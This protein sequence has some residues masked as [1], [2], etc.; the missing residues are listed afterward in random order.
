MKSPGNEFFF[1]ITVAI[2]SHVR[3]IENNMKSRRM[4]RMTVFSHHD[5]FILN[6]RELFR[7]GNFPNAISQIFFFFRMDI[8]NAGMYCHGNER[9]KKGRK[10]D[11]TIQTHPHLNGIPYSL[12]PLLLT[13]SSQH[14]NQLPPRHRRRLPNRTELTMRNILCRIRSLVKRKKGIRKKSI[15]KN[16]IRK[17]V[18]EAC[19]FFFLN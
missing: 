13:N 14:K 4:A 7:M 1:G 17:N 12:T 2:L 11:F 10:T 9:E 18:R 3:L 19:F 16:G 6:L 15:R 5:T 8:F